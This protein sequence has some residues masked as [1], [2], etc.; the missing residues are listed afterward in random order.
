M[1][2]PPSIL[3]GNQEQKKPDLYYCIIYW[4]WILEKR[5]TFFVLQ[6]DL[7]VPLF[8]SLK[9]VFFPIGKLAFLRKNYH[10]CPFNPSG[11]NLMFPLRN[12]LFYRCRPIKQENGFIIKFF[13]GRENC[14]RKILQYALLY[15]N[16]WQESSSFEKQ[17]S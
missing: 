8:Y 15:E 13:R 12:F 4:Y 1:M 14:L 10:F 5:V 7:K 2:S 16:Y 6:K 17:H 9:K 11:S 3:A